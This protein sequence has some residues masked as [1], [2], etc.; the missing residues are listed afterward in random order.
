MAIN[1]ISIFVENS[2]GRLAEVTA[3]MGD[4]G[5]D[6]RAMCIADTADFGILRVIVSN[7]KRALEILR[8]S[9]C[10]VS[11]TQVLAI[12]I[13]DTP[14][15]LSRVIGILADAGVSV[16]YAYAFITRKKGNAYVIFRVED[17]ERAEEIL[18][19]NGIETA[20]ESELYEL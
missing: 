18:A 8:A 7:P 15:S 4:A 19:R 14:G 12:S 9:E 5:I 3:V 1:Q 16:E 2:V 10:V 17:N 20:N 13:P 11:V 6:M